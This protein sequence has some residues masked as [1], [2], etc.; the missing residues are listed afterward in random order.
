MRLELSLSPRPGPAIEEEVRCGCGSLL[1]R[2]NGD[3]IELKCR[4]CRRRVL[5]RLL[6]DGGVELLD[7]A[8]VAAGR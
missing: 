4:R 8:D 7:G 1:A 5:L 2:R 3:L 6:P